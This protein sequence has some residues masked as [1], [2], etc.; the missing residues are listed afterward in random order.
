[1]SLLQ[2]LIVGALVTFGVKN[3]KEVKVEEKVAEV[4]V[5]EKKQEE[6]VKPEPETFKPTEQTIVAEPVQEK[7]APVV[8]PVK[9][10]PEEFK[11][12]E[13]TVVAEPKPTEEVKEQTNSLDKFYTEYANDGGLSENSYSELA[14]MGINRQTV[15]AYI[16]GQEALQ[17]QHTASIMSTVGG[18]ENYNNMVQWAS[19]NLSKSEIEAFNKTVDTGTIEQAQ[20]AIAGI[21]AKYQ[22]NTREPNLFSGHKADTNEGYESVAQMLTDIN[23]PKYQTDSAFRKKVENKVKNSNVL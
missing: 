11:P 23:N 22:S 19:Q 8:E 1:M 4:Q 17:Q 9:P 16:S 7:P 6:V 5:E 21:N 12:T 10:Q 15:D 14:K 20:L 18:Q 2:L 3:T 13:Q